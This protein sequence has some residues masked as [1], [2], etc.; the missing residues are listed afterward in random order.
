MILNFREIML[1]CKL[2]LVIEIIT[3]ITFFQIL[4]LVQEMMKVCS[5]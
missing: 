1:S 3:Q 4:T 2:H 5:I